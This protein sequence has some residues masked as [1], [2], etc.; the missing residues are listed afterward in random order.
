[1]KKRLR[2]LLSFISIIFTFGCQTKTEYVEHVEY[3]GEKDLFHLVEIGDLA[4]LQEYSQEE[5]SVV[6]S[7]GLTLLHAATMHNR[8]KIAEFLIE[9]G[10]S[11]EARDNYSRTPLLLGVY[12]DSFDTCNILINNNAHIFAKDKDQNTPFNYA[13]TKESY[14]HFLT[15]E[16]IKQKD[17]DDATPLHHA[18]KL[19]NKKLVDFILSL[20]KSC[21]EK[22]KFGK[23]PV[24]L[25]YDKI[26]NRVSVEILVSILLA[27]G[28]PQGGE[29]EKFEIATSR[30]NFETRFENGN[31]P[32]HIAAKKGQVGIAEFL[33]SKNVS[34]DAKNL[35]GSTPLHEAVRN[36]NV[37]VALLLLNANANPNARD[38]NGNTAMHLVMPEASRSV[39]F[40]ELLKHGADV[41]IQDDYGETPI[42]VASR[43]G[44]NEDIIKILVKAGA[45]PNERNKNGQ[46]PLM[47]S[48]ERNNLKQAKIFIDLGVNIHDKD[49]E[50]I[51]SF[52]RA[53]D[54]GLDAVKLMVNKNN[55]A[56]RDS[57]GRTPLHIAVIKNANMEIIN[58]LL[59]EGAE[60]NTRDKDGNTSLHAAVKNNSKEVGLLLIY[61]NADVFTTNNDGYSPLRLSYDLNDGQEEWFINEQTINST[62]A[63]GNSPLHLAAEWN[64]PKMVTYL[65]NRGANINAKNDNG[66]TPFFS[67]VKGNSPACIDALISY[68]KANI[69]IAARDFMGNCVMHSA[70]QWSAYEA[71]AKIVSMTD[72]TKLINARNLAGK[73]PLHIASE[74]GKLTFIKMFLSYGID[75]DETDEM[76]HS[77]LVYAINGNK[78]EAVKYLLSKNASP[79]LLNMYG[80][81]PLHFAVENRNVKCVKILRA[82]GANAMTKDSYG[83]TPLS[84]GMNQNI[85]MLDA[86]LANEKHMQSSDGE[87]PLHIAVT[88]NLSAE[89]FNFLL[90]KGC[91]VNKRNKNGNTCLLLAIQLRQKNLIEILLK[92]NADVFITN[93]LGKSPISVVLTEYT[94][95]LE[96]FSKNMNDK[97]DTVGDTIL[98]YAVKLCDGNIVQKLLSLGHNARIQNMEG[99][100]PLDLAI[101][102][103]KKDVESVLRNSDAFRA[104]DSEITKSENDE[105]SL[106]KP[107]K[108]ETEEPTEQ[109]TENLKDTP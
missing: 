3:V 11:V 93:N 99:H 108:Y 36:G 26:E 106:T 4:S 46:T 43:I 63:M 40:T 42:H 30:R 58:Y 15:K 44:M 7:E 10:N 18:V 14:R 8:P 60:L 65:L 109:N 13:V 94:E 74:L 41:S 51:S 85:N 67:C 56:I 54:L 95:Y 72:G 5:L 70:I 29:Y 23:T 32:L 21:N 37:D 68:P 61:K 45:D 90:A 27:G 83:K 52:M 64:N 2:L 79:T 1:M 55:I 78:L 87:S 47:L 81:A 33:I 38:A 71:T 34:I 104:I 103:E 92:N 100:T 25:A 57:L 86:I 20:D 84:L 24:D 66:E 53:I 22:D 62:D 59:D 80:Q 98:H 101:Q 69:D 105:S 28:Q 17:A 91:P 88:E 35:S 12:G 96:T 73:T 75:I 39:L 6:N 50:Q 102:W 97:P 107:N 82:A 48:V 31:T 49:N 77:A 16:N 89:K 9:Q 19:Q 76:G